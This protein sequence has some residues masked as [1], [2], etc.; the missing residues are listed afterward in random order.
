MGT[1]FKV[2]IEFVKTLL[3]IYFGHEAL[4]VPEQGLNPLPPALKAKVLTTG[5]PGKSQGVLII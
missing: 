5:P 2:F 1:I 3:V 4:W